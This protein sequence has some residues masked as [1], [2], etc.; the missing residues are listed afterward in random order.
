MV[1]VRESGLIYVFFEDG[2]DP[3]WANFDDAWREGEPESDPDL[4]P[5]PGLQQPVRGFGEVWRDEPDVR[6]RLGWATASERA[7]EITLQA[8]DESEEEVARYLTWLDGK[9][10]ELKLGGEDWDIVRP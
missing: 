6:S 4:S 2:G 7:Y 3:A 10:V 9:V 1:W 8:A 5:P